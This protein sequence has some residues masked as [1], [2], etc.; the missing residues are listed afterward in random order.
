MVNRVSAGRTVWILKQSP[1]QD[2]KISPRF[3]ASRHWLGHDV[4]SLGVS[5]DE[6][7]RHQSFANATI[8]TLVAS[9]GGDVRSIDPTPYLC[10]V[11][12]EHPN[13]CPAARDGGSM[14]RDEDHLS[15]YGTKYLRPLFLPFFESF[16]NTTLSLEQHD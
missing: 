4:G 6:H 3:L 1:L 2:D 14:Y 15:T 9:G 7:N 16:S 11:G 5:V 12:L 13:I 8:D 10:G